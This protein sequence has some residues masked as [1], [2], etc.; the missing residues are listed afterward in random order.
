MFTKLITAALAFSCLALAG[1]DTLNDY[2]VKTVDGQP[3]VMRWPVVATG[4]VEEVRV[5]EKDGTVHNISKAAGSVAGEYAG[6]TKLLTDLGGMSNLG[7]GA[8]A[9]GIGAVFDIIAAISA[10]RIELMVRRS[11]E[12][13]LINVPVSPDTLKIAQDMHCVQ[14]GDD[15]NVVK[16][17]RAF[18]VY[19]ANPNLL[20]LSDFQPSCDDLRSKAG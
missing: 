14:I 1:C 13:D 7:A 9:G 15:V 12:Q 11:A 8:V 16:K 4:Q 5:T 17:G 18:D 2:R 19:N 10:P 20:R 3:Y 6:S